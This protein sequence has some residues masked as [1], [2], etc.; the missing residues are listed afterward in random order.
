MRD[1][2]SRDAR[3][4]PAPTTTPIR[5]SSYVLSWPRVL[6]LS[7][8]EVARAAALPL[9][10]L[11]SGEALTYEDTLRLWRGIEALTGDPVWGLHA[12]ARF[13]LDQ[14]GV[15]GTALAHATH[16]DAAIDALTRVMRYFVQGAA[17]RRVDSAVAAG[18]EYKMPTLRSRHGA[19]TIFAATMA[20]VRHC[21]GQ[22]L[23]AHAVEHQMPRC[24]EDEYARFF[25]VAPAWDR[26]TTQLLFSRDSLALPFR[27]AAPG[28]AELLSEHA[29]R[30]LAPASQSSP[31]AQAFSEAFW[32]AHEAGDATIDTV[33]ALL[34][35]SARSLQRKLA[36]TGK[37][38]A[39][40]RAELLHRRAYELLIED[41]LTIEAIA[42]RLGY[43]S[44]AALERAF[45]RWC[46][47]T[48]HAV[49]RDRR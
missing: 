15:V 18:I 29:Q 2:A 34:G 31:F 23:A 33:A 1:I 43:S 17:I 27:G 37:T 32:R 4:E 22:A 41:A 3:L 11:E 36:A 19:D 12:G 47:R 30:L 9:E 45:V 42:A 39:T 38:F 21:T 8:P 16:L 49:R 25:G 5:V 7:L 40:T 26:P 46:G 24:C 48:P 20:L 44:R 14:M 13:T 6:G 28:V 35:T 10:R